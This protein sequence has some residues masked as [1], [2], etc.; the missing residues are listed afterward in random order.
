MIT[1]PTPRRTH[2]RNKRQRPGPR[3]HVEIN[4]AYWTSRFP[5]YD[6]ITSDAERDEL[7]H[8]VI[9][10]IQ[11][12]LNT[13]RPKRK[14]LLLVTNEHIRLKRTPPGSNNDTVV[15]TPLDWSVEGE[16]HRP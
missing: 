7:I 2:K 6:V 5:Y 3:Y 4:T 9:A 8:R 16:Q 12:F 1:R 13:R 11:R 14:V 10:D 15:V